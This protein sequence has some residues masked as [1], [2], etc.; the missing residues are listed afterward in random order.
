MDNE[1][2]FIYDRKK[3]SIIL[4]IIT[5]FI[6]FIAVFYLSALGSFFQSPIIVFIWFLLMVFF[7]HLLIPNVTKSR[8]KGMLHDD[9]MEIKLKNVKHIIKYCDIFSVELHIINH[10]YT[11][12]HIEIIKNDKSK[13]MIEAVAGMVAAKNEEQYHSFYY[14]IKN[15]I[16]NSDIKNVIFGHYLTDTNYNNFRQEKVKID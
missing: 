4:S 3:Y 14:A 1:Y 16:T 13:I 11:W 12:A 2:E 9:Y 7:Q 15:I 8:G 6:S 10:R 5:T